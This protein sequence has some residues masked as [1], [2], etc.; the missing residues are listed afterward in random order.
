MRRGLLSLTIIREGWSGTVI[1]T[2]EP[3][4]LGCSRIGGPA[5]ARPGGPSGVEGRRPGFVVNPCRRGRRPRRHGLGA[6]PYPGVAERR[7][8]GSFGEGVAMHSA[9][10]IS[11]YHTVVALRLHIVGWRLRPR[12]AHTPCATTAVNH[13]AGTPCLS[14]ARP[15]RP[16]SRGTWPRAS[17]VRNV[18]L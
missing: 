5:R 6:L 1:S 16:H 3:L 14:S 9:Q 10:Y 17:L 13:K 11:A 15:S 4:H 2:A 12:P 7:L 18:D 8:C